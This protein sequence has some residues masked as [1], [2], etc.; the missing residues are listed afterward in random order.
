MREETSVTLKCVNHLRGG[1]EREIDRERAFCC[2]SVGF[3]RIEE[4]K[5][6]KKNQNSRKKVMG[7]IA[8]IAGPLVV[9][10]FFLST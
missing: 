8:R 10:L 5:A 6:K 1:T 7:G 3:I 9:S 2:Y 4:K